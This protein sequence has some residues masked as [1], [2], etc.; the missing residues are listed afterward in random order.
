MPMVALRRELPARLLRGSA[1]ALAAFALGIAGF[2]CG[3]K[4]EPDLSTVPQTETLPT[5]PAPTTTA[6]TPPAPT[7]TAP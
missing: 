1:V 6:P 3:E 5:T 4:E 2:G 7:P